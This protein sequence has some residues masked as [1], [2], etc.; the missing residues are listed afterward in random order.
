M[1]P[2]RA[3]TDAT[4]D[5]VGITVT[6]VDAALAF[7]A[8]LGFET[9]G[10]AVLEGEFVDTVI[11]IPGSRTEIVMLRPPGGG[12]GLE[13]SRFIRPDAE[14]ASRNALANVVG[15]RNLGFEVADLQAILDRLA[16]DGYRPIGAVGEYEGTW[17][18]AHV[19]G[20]DGIIV[21]LA[22]RID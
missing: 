12:T 17:R 4:F 15:L 14:P 2:L 1:R 6:N 8:A 20:P 16:A 10:R 11:G 18:M 7:F 21:A 5:H 9:E 19:R 3:L 22:Q 13:L